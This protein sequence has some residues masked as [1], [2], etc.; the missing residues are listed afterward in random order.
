MSGVTQPWGHLLVAPRF[1]P[2][3]R[4]PSDLPAPTLCWRGHGMLPGAPRLESQSGQGLPLPHIQLQPRPRGLTLIQN[5]PLSTSSLPRVRP[6]HIRPQPLPATS[7]PPV[8]AFVA[9]LLKFYLFIHFWLLGLLVAAWGRLSSWGA[10]P[11]HRGVCGAC[12]L[13]LGLQEL[14]LHRLTCPS[15]RGS[16]LD[17]GSNLSSAVAGGFLTRKS[18]V[19]AFE[20]PTPIPWPWSGYFQSPVSPQGGWRAGC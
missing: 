3:P 10:W 2:R 16:F 8:T 15:T 7:F 17:Q 1:G 20:P 18:P 14:C 5:Q 9:K 6:P 19:T 11:S 12:A 4:T 13:G